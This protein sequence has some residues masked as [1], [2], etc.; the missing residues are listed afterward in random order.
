MA[1]EAAGSVVDEEEDSEDTRLPFHHRLRVHLDRFSLGKS[2]SDIHKFDVTI[3]R[4]VSL[5]F[6]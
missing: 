3:S 1:G 4:I 2:S 6:K 5:L